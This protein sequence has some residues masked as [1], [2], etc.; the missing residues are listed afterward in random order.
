[1]LGLDRLFVVFVGVLNPQQYAL[2]RHK[3]FLVDREMN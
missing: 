3:E 1:M 2:E